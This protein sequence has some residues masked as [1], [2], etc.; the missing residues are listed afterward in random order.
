MPPAQLFTCHFPAECVGMADFYQTKPP[1][2]PQHFL[3][4]I[5]YS[6]LPHL[7]SSALQSIQAHS[8][9]PQ[10]ICSLLL[11]VSPV[12]R[13]LSWHTASLLLLSPTGCS[14]SDSSKLPGHCIGWTP[15]DSDLEGC[16]Y[17]SPPAHQLSKADTFVW[18]HSLTQTRHI[19]SGGLEPTADPSQALPAERD[20]H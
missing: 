8:Q 5:G 7:Q 14:R 19:H 2:R 17:C 15:R 12:L 11:F 13:A 10:D 16:T 1:G 4:Y 18:V 6:Q 9:Q 20:Q 3:S